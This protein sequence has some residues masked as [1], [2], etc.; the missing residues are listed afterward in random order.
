MGELKYFTA[1]EI[2]SE[3]HLISQPKADSFSSRGSQ[4]Y[5][6]KKEKKNGRT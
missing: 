2:A 3:K 4:N 5:S 6:I 1:E